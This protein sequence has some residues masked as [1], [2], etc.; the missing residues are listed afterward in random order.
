[1]IDRVLSIID[2]VAYLKRIMPKYV[3]WT[4]R[5]ARMASILHRRYPHGLPEYLAVSVSVENQEIAIERLPHLLGIHGIR[6][7]ILEPMLGP[8]SFERYLPVEWVVVDSETG[9][10]ATTG[11]KTGGYSSQ[12]VISRLRNSRRHT[13]YTE[14]EVLAVGAGLT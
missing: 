10:G 14:Q 3:L 7:T 13:I 6:I 5:V 2:H 4:K 12:S 1:V 8:I 9:T 11:S